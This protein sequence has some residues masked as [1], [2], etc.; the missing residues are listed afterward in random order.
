MITSDLD[1]KH[2]KTLSFRA[3]M[4]F[5]VHDILIVASLYDAFK[6]EEGG[7]ITEMV[8]ME[9]HQLKLNNP[10]HIIRVSTAGEALEYLEHNRVDLVITMARLGDMNAEEFGAQFNKRH[11]DIPL[12]LLAADK[13][14]LEATP[15]PDSPFEFVF[16]WVGTPS[17]LPAIIKV[18]EDKHNA[19]R[20]ILEGS[21]RCIIVVE[22]SP[23]Y[24]SVFMSM[25]YREIIQHTQH[26]MR[27]EYTDALRLLRM[28]SR[29]KILLATTYE[30][31]LAYF[32]KYQQNALA[33]ISDVRYP[34]G[35]VLDPNA[36][37]SLLSLIHNT[38]GDLPIVLQ[39]KDRKNRTKAQQMNG[40]FLDKNSPRLVKDLREF[41]V[42]HCGFG[43][44]VFSS[45]DG[46]LI[47]E[48]SD[49]RGLE[50]A[51]TK[52]PEQSIEYHARRNHFSNWLAARGYF[53][54]ADEIKPLHVSDFKHVDELRNVL[55]QMVSRE[56][57]TQ[58]QD[59]ILDFVAETYDPAFRFVRIGTGSLGGKARGLAF[60]STFLRRFEWH[61]KYP[62]VA[63]DIPHTSVVATDIFDQFMEMNRIQPALPDAESNEEIDAVFRA[64]QFPE[65]FVSD[66]RA[67][68]EYH[69]VPLAVRS[70]SL[71]EDSLFQP[72]AG[73]YATFMVPNNAPDIDTRLNMVLNA[74]KLVYASTF[75]LE[76]Q[77]YMTA[78]GNRPEDEKMAVIIQNLVGTR[79]GDYF[80]PT[81]SGIAQSYNYYPFKNMKRE[82]GIANVALGLGRTVVLGNKSLSF[83]PKFPKILPQFYD[84]RS[85]LKN[86][87]ST[88]FALP[89]NS[90]RDP[91]A[92]GERG[93]LELLSIQ[94]AEKD[95]T[96]E[97]LT[98]VYD[99]NDNTFVEAPDLKGPRVLTF[100]NILK[101]D[102][103]P[104]ADILQNLLHYGRRG[105]GCEVEIEFAANVGMDQDAQ[106]VFNILQIRPM[107]TYAQLT[108]LDPDTL[109]KK[110]VICHSDRCLGHGTTYDIRDIV[111]VKPE[112][113][114]VQETHE[115]AS[116]IAKLNKS[117]NEKHHYL[118]MGP[119]RWGTADPFLGIPVSWDDISLARG[120]VEVGLPKLFIEPSFGSHFFQNLTTL[121][122]SY[123][124]IPPEDYETAIDWDWLYH[125]EAAEETK[126]LRHLRFKKP[127][128]IRIDGR[129]G[130]GA[131]FKPGRQSDVNDL[132]N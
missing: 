99:A 52:V 9:Y 102:V 45:R 54:L 72:F 97:P 25:I 24:Y 132:T 106:T 5:R 131:V 128:P 63:V 81:I 120:I 10:P 41:V 22:D 117:L 35:G 66:V 50:K 26:L 122:V 2:H 78:T 104:L 88:F 37:V 83:C 12:I 23:Q 13:R 28:R 58:Y 129:T 4:Q 112:A 119:G 67:Y 18:V 47:K 42:K 29:P 14:I 21:V 62:N 65:S 113:F 101:W 130:F 1:F 115:I 82:H 110:D 103:F 73:I 91:L 111:L 123:F 108:V 34:K 76:S 33:V 53:R 126:Y 116:E 77:S 8:F 56:R 40:Y 124:T 55:I 96:L 30:E 46:T 17:L 3:L 43:N 39:S 95:G 75:H 49:L 57:A 69:Q 79:F 70:S 61:T 121:G 64:G 80:Y 105:M 100:A 93:N 92:D 36:G 127:L 86:S 84:A 19:E 118:L 48:V 38:D 16:A 74:I 125:L 71:L 107:L 7:H 51:L 94:H 6:L 60:I 90:E 27:N 59:K 85:V 31:G 89:M 32:K 98:S 109:N 15:D 87:Q 114:S 68:L 44:L 11:P 20:D